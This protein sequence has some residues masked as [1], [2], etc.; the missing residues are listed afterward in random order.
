MIKLAT[1][2]LKR[3]MISK[4]F[5]I[6]TDYAIQKWNFLS[7]LWKF[8][9][10]IRPQP[11]RKFKNINVFE[12]SHYFSLILLETKSPFLD[13]NPAIESFPVRSR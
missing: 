2:K 10:E 4:L 8:S 7:W 13:E 12:K 3:K 9:N 5:M 1:E 6:L 11:P